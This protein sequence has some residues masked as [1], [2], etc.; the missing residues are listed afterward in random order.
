MSKTLRY[1]LF[2]VGAMPDGLRDEIKQEQ[3]LF[4]DEGIPVTVRRRGTAPGFSGGATGKFSGAV[5]ITDRRIVASVSK[6][7]MVDAPYEAK[8]ATGAGLSIKEDGLHVTVD[9]SVNPRCSGEI[10]MHF[11][12]EFTTQRIDQFPSRQ[13]SFHFAPELVPK[14]FGVPI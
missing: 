6:T 4:L 13:M 10:E 1:R 11:K 8:D 12:A 3:V 9:A 5:A 7:I 14:I 2:K